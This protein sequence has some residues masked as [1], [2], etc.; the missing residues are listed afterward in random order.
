MFKKLLIILLGAGSLALSSCADSGHHGDNYNFESKDFTANRVVV[1]VVEHESL[2]ALHVQYEKDSD[3][4]AKRDGKI[5][6][7]YTLY[8]YDEAT[9][10]NHCIIHIID[11]AHKYVP[12][13]IG[14]EFIHCI[15]GQWHPNQ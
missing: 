2:A 12:E 4:S 13:F 5:V 3:K 11:P 6:Q 9:N 1:D 10:T 15:H 14:H 7:A 8:K